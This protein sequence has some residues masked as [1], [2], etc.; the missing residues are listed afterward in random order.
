MNL[1]VYA[2]ASRGA[3]PM[4]LRGVVG[5][6]LTIVRIGSIDA[7]VG[8][9]TAPPRATAPTLRRYDRIVRALWARRSAVL[10][11]RFPS[12][13][14]DR[15]EL[16]LVLRAR[17]PTFQRQL[18][19]VRQR[20][21]MTVRIVSGSAVR[22]PGSGRSA[23]PGGALRSGKAEDS[24]RGRSRGTRYLMHRARAARLDH[25]PEVDLVRDAVKQWIRAERAEARADVATLYHLVPRSAA[26]RYQQAVERTAAATHLRLRVSGPWPA[27]AFAE[28]W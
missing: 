10:P 9:V 20:A 12:V 25:V 14:H 4:R 3:G 21:Q 22:D 28:A 8:A 17:R 23:R 2:L 13:L 19:I 16:E 15:A 7:I 18:A 26:R 1:L 27:Y 5:E 11:A 6:R 24:L